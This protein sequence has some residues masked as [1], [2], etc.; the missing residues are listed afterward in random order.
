M[1]Q[2]KDLNAKLSRIGT[3]IDQPRHDL[4]ASVSQKKVE[5]RDKPER[6]QEDDGDAQEEQGQMGRGVRAAK[7]VKG[8]EANIG[9][10]GAAIKWEVKDTQLNTTAKDG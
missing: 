10:S 5:V 3:T 1:S 6:V 4:H 7:K 2:V 9:P 8:K